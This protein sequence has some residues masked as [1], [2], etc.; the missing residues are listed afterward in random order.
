MRVVD[1]L[2]GAGVAELADVQAADGPPAPRR[3][4]PARTRR[5]PWRCP[6]SPVIWKVSS[7]ERPSF[8][9]SPLVAPLS[10]DLICATAR[11]CGKARNE[12][13]DGRAILGAPQACR[14]GSGSAP[15]RP[16]RSRRELLAP[17]SGW[18]RSDSPLPRSCVLQRDRAGRVPDRE[19]DKYERQPAEH[20]RLAVRRAPARGAGGERGRGHAC[21]AR[22]QNP[23]GHP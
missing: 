18:P 8:E 19:R 14:C 17:G 1:R 15:A 13:G 16:A 20:R 22:R 21:D 4:Q 3:S 9:S 11:T 23:D 10:G 12:V 5:D 7:A 2:V 6:G